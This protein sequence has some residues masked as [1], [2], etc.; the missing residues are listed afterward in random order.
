[1]GGNGTCIGII[2]KDD[3]FW[4]MMPCSV[5]FYPCFETL[6]PV[7]DTGCHIP[8]EQNLSVINVETGFDKRAEGIVMVQC[9]YC[10]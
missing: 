10:F 5:L 7:C 1:V 8:E 3:N 2:G 6:V 9:Q 4:D